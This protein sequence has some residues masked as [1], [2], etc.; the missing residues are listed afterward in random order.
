MDLDHALPLARTAQRV[1]AAQP[2]KHRLRP[3]R[4]LRHRLVRDCDRLLTVLCEEL[5]KTTLE[6]LGGDLLT[7]ADAL[8]WLERRAAQVLRPRRVPRSDRPIALW[9]QRDCVYRRPRG[10]VGIIGTWN[11]PLFLNAVQICQALVAGNAVIWKPSEVAP[12][13]ADIFATLM[14]EVGW[15]EQLF[16]ALPATRE[17]GA[18]LADLPLD[19]VVFTGSAEVGRKLA[20]HLGARLIPSTLE[21]SGCD[22]MFL[23]DDAD[24]LLAAKA[25]AFGVSINRGQT[26]IAVRRV[27]VPRSQMEAFSQLLLQLLPPQPMPLQ[28]PAQEQ[29]A[30]RLVEDALA[31]GARL[32]SAPLASPSE[33]FHGPIVLADVRPC[34]ALCREAAFAPIVGLLPYDSLDEALQAEASCPMAL[35]CSIFTAQPQKGEALAGLLRAGSVCVNDVIAPTA[36]PATPFGGHGQ[37]GWGVTQGAEGLLEMT[38]PQVV[39]VRSG[40][41]RPHYEPSPN[42]EGLLRGLLAG[43]HAGNLSARWS[44]WWLVVRTVLKGV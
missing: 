35:S 39:S 33:P 11:Y 26:C 32:L 22:A 14:R 9:G 36:H 5:H 4:V 2:V 28:L 6:A 12:R 19:H 27:F 3:V 10:V 44:G 16:Q 40:R 30:R 20:S 24:W 13:F 43:S 1:W 37:S 8:A 25:A 38:V 7:T 31:Q 15:P 41:F 23:L 29:Q 18:R 42:Q 34:M 17:G 21:L